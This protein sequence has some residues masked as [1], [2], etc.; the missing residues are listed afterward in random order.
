MGMKTAISLPDPVFRSAER[1]AARLGVSRSELYC[2]ALKDL[3][4]RHDEAAVT[5]QLDV[6]YGDRAADAGLDP[7]LAAL[8]AT[9]IRK[10]GGQ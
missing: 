7:G 6:V 10:H 2:R 4:A 5:A 3:L 9:S 1:L 8:Q